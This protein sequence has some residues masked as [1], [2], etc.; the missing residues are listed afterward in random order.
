MKFLLSLTLVIMSCFAH[1]A[2]AQDHNNELAPGYYLVVG[3]YADTKEDVAAK[4]VEKLNA[5][6]HKASY[7]FNSSRNLYF[8]YLHYYVDLKESIRG[9]LHLRKTATFSDSWVRVVPGDIQQAKPIANGKVDKNEE[10][11]E[12]EPAAEQDALEPDGEIVQYDPMTLGNTEVFLSLFN[13]ANKRIIDG[14][15]E[16]YDAN[17]KLLKTVKGN[18]YL[19]LPDPKS[20]SGAITLVANI[21]GYE[22]IVQAFNYNLP[23]P[24]TAKQYIDLMGTTFVVHFDM[25]RYKQGAK[26]TLS[27]IVFYNDA[28]LM[29]PESQNELSSLQKL[30]KENPTYRIRLTAHTNGNNTGKIIEVGPSKNYFTISSDSRRGNGSS[31]TLSAKRAEVIKAWLL[32]MGIDGSRIETQG[33]G[34]KEPLYDSK[35][36]NAKKNERVEL[37]ILK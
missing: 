32:D 25:V 13:A 8:V 6:G 14:D 28:A 24:D 30:M 5:Q 33:V 3:A 16:V 19:I 9:M 34:G 37:E 18:E 21:F 20:T 7:G 23:L 1:V 11:F 29:Q 2:L 4:Y 27:N 31:K 36:L 10:I 15:I 12:Q 35:D 22:K 17:D 26:T